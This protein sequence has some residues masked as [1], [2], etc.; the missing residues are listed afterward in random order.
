MTY[1]HFSREFI[2]ISNIL[3]IIVS[4]SANRG[5]KILNPTTYICFKT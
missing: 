1:V 2:I 5:R 3:V 4:G